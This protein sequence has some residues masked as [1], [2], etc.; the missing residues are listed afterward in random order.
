[1]RNVSRLNAVVGCVGITCLAFFWICALVPS[2]ADI[3][4]NSSPGK[5]VVV[6]IFVA[7][8]PLTIVAAIRGSRWWWIAVAASAITLYLFYS[9]FR[10]RA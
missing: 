6:S 7:S 9:L 3:L 2:V 4:P 8:L 10:L 5:I 1:M